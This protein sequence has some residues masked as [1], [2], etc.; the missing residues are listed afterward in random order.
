MKNSSLSGISAIVKEVLEHKTF[1][2]IRGALGRA[3]K[4]SE[5]VTPEVAARFLADQTF[6]KTLIGVRSQS[7]WRDRMLNDPVNTE[8]SVPLEA[9]GP[10][11]TRSTDSIAE[12]ALKSANAYIQWSTQGFKEV[13]SETLERRRNACLG[14]DQLK[15]APE[16]LAYRLALVVARDDP[17]VCMACGCLFMKKTAMPNEACP[18]PAAGDQNSTRWDEPIL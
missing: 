7:E 17:R 6:A 12:L 16:T 1:G 8:F 15:D 10:A 4:L 2:A 18:M 5:P 3:I 11:D 9:G 14:C 13:D